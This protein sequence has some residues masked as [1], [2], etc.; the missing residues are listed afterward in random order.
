MIPT[1]KSWVSKIS[2]D[3]GNCIRIIV[4]HDIVV[5]P[6]KIFVECVGVIMDILVPQMVIDRRGVSIMSASFA[7]RRVTHLRFDVVLV[8]MEYEME[9]ECCSESRIGSRASRGGSEWSGE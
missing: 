6:I 4:V 2:R 9:T 3:K 5:Q 8:D 7:N 1:I